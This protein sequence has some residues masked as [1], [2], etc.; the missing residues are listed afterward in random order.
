MKG[1]PPS[2]KPA[3]SNVCRKNECI[4]LMNKSCDKMLPCG[5]VCCGFKDE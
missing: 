3:F 2:L 1:A 5:H 4:E